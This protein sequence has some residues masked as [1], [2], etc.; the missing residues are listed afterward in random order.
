[1][2][3]HGF[4][5]NDLNLSRR[6]FIRDCGMGMGALTLGTMLAMEAPPT[7]TPLTPSPPWRSMRVK[8][9]RWNT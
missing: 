9:F 2:G 7:L 8:C 6:D 1:M 5:I 4:N 3:H